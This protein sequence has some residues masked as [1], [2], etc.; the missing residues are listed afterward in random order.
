MT[1]DDKASVR[2]FLVIKYDSVH[3]E[4]LECIRWSVIKKENG[5]DYCHTFLYTE[6]KICDFLFCRL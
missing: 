2:G 6:P 4:D 3:V 5:P 1:V